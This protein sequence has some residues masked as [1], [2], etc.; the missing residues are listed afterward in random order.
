MVDT[1]A[2]P[3]TS[4]NP[5]AAHKLINYMLGA[6]TAAQLTLE[7]GYPTSNIKAL[8]L[9]P[10]E[11]TQDPAI[12]PTAEVLQTVTGKMMSVMVQYYEEFYQKLK[13]QNNLCNNKR[14]A[15][16]GAFLF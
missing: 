5:D 15:P 8:E 11:I 14:N 7:I 1:L 2:I 4:K 12:Y 16:I 6:K 9:L 13:Q 10:P 3:S